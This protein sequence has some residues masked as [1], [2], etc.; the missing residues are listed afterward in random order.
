MPQAIANVQRDDGLARRLIAQRMCSGGHGPL[1]VKHRHRA[2]PP[3]LPVGAPATCTQPVPAR[4][5]LSFGEQLLSANHNLAEHCHDLLAVL[6]LA[7][8]LAMARIMHAGR[9]PCS[10]LSVA[11]AT[12]VAQILCSVAP[13]WWRKQLRANNS[14]QTHQRT[15]YRFLQSRGAS[16]GQRSKCSRAEVPRKGMRQSGYQ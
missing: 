12:A 7:L 11:L 4:R 13:H 8:T 1:S 14:E 2:R 3:S 9:Q 16:T 15:T 6:V 5:A 10:R